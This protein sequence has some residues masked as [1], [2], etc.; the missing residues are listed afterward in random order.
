MGTIGDFSRLQAAIERAWRLSDFYRAHWLARGVPQDWVPGDPAELD[1][2]PVVTKEDLLAAQRRSPPWGGNLCIEERDIAQVHLTTGTS[3]IGQERYAM[4]A[5]DVDV[6]GRSWGPQY[7]AIGL[8]RG[9]VVC[10]TIPVSFFCAG[11]SA[12]EGARIHGLVPILTGV[13]SKELM[14]DLLTQHPVRYLYGVESL[15]LQLANL[16]RERGISWRGQFKGVQA[17]GTSPQM[18]QAA[19]EVFGAPLFEIY[20]C[21]QASAKIASTCRLGVEEGSN[22]FHGEHLFIETRDL[23]TGAY[24]DEGD[25]E[26]VISTPYRQAS[27]VIRFAIRDQVRLVGPRACACGSTHPGFVP[28]SLGRID[29][30]LKIRGVN[31]WPQQVEQLLLSHPAVRDFRAEVRRNPDGG[32]E[33]LLRVATTEQASP[34]L[35]ETLG[36]LVREKTM[37]RPRVVVDQ[38]L[39]DSLGLYKVRRWEDRRRA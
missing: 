4:S 23:R 36:A 10:L 1:Q 5:P 11:L 3:G 8:G 26:L 25:A 34:T 24:V 14:L 9:D 16:A 31:L 20:G 39:P 2:L 17:V 21:T 18:Q 19:R 33:L 7:E 38:T 37:V 13:A 29:S 6:M 12:L 32:E 28:G 15:L 27:P 22:H 30:M 35:E